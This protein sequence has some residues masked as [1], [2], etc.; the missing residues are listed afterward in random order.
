MSSH[1][2]NMF[3]PLLSAG[4]SILALPGCESSGSYRVASV[5][6]A[7][8]QGVGAPESAQD[9][10]APGSTDSGAA[11]GGMSNGGQAGSEGSGGS[12]GLGGTKAVATGGLVGPGGAAGTG[13]LANTGDPNNRNPRV[14]G[15]LVAS[16]KAASAL[17][18]RGTPLAERIDSRTPGGMN[19]TGRVIRSAG[20]GGQ[21]LVRAGNGQDY[22]VDGLTAAPGQL[23]TVTANNARPIGSPNQSALIAGSAFST[24]QERGDAVTAGAQ[25]GGH[26]T[27][28]GT[29]VTGT[30]TTNAGNGTL[31]AVNLPVAS[32]L[33]LPRGN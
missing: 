24:N 8:A 30:Q 23:V 9:E 7:G 31:P 12:G 33:P 18:A 16:G 25:S 19:I 28:V 17:A 15:V 11:D 22:L 5:D 6:S 32:P 10:S 13:L 3:V 1:V 20:A 14:S 2:R 27:T 26:T 29:P 4:I 21:A